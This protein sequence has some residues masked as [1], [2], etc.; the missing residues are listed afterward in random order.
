[1]NSTYTESQRGDARLL[2]TAVRSNPPDKQ[3]IIKVMAN[4]YIN[5]MKD[6]ERLAAANLQQT[7]AC[8]SA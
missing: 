5:G 6:Q 1:M 2:Y 8:E 3:T 4:T 7:D